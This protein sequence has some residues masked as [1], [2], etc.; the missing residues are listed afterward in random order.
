LNTHPTPEN[1]QPAGLR[2]RELFRSETEFGYPFN[3]IQIPNNAGKFGKEW[4]KKK[5]RQKEGEG[6][7]RRER[8]RERRVACA[9]VA[10]KI[11]FLQ[12]EDRFVVLLL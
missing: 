7:G 9:V 11:L 3:K 8:E 6:R 10:T 1:K 5:W 2:F 4:E 12:G